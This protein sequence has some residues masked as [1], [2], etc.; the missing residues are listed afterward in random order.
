[1]CGPTKALQ[2]VSQEGGDI[3]AWGP[4]AAAGHSTDPL[5]PKAILH[6]TYRSDHLHSV[7]S[8]PVTL[9][10]ELCMMSRLALPCW[11]NPR[12]PEKILSCSNHM[13]MLSSHP[14]GLLFPRSQEGCF[15]QP[16]GLES[17]PPGLTMNCFLTAF[18]SFQRFIFQCLI[19]HR[20]LKHT[21][22]PKNQKAV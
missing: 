7:P 9:Y 10:L 13:V 14:L 1:M 20:P 6:C 12:L 4:H 16:G 5:L 11:S 15:R 22:L 21:I 8:A 3:R 18:F 19:S 17:L 2:M